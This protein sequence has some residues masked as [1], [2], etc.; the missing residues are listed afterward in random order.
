MRPV[1]LLW[2][3]LL[4]S[5]AENRDTSFSTRPPGLDIAD[6]ALAN[7]APDTALHIAQQVLATDPR[8]LPALIRAA[9]AQAALGQRDQ[10]AKIFSQAL[11]VA[12]DN[13]DAALGLGRLKLATDPAAAFAAFLRI[14]ARDPRNV[15]ALIDLR[16]RERPARPAR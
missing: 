1:L 10:A 16:N 8:N 4:V 15:A 14:T 6:V 2:L 7:G 11:A 3:L 5:C 9:N 12:P 13:N